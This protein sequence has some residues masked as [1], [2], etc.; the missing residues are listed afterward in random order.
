MGLTLKGPLVNFWAIADLFSLKIRLIYATGC[1]ER[2]I[3][4]LVVGLEPR[5]SGA[6]GDQSANCALPSAQLRYITRGTILIRVYL[7]LI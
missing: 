3:F 4:L 1:L 6:G 2:K 5:I 7:S